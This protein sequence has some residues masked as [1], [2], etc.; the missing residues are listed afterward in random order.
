MEFPG[1][2]NMLK[3]ALVRMRAE[4]LVP[5]VGVDDDLLR[6]RVA[7]G[8]KK[9]EV[10]QDTIKKAIEDEDYTFISME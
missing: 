10:E 4:E 5:A 1:A 6:E 2:R 3:R 9:G 8:A 7:R